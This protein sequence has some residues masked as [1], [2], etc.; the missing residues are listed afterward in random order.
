MAL[1]LQVATFAVNYRGHPF[2]ES[3]LENKPMLYSLLFSG[4][5]VFA[6]ASGI[7]PELLEKFELVELPVGLLSGLLPKSQSI[8]AYLVVIVYFAKFVRLITVFTV[9]EITS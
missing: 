7:S 4:S 1:A 5:A 8:P 6:L 2:M 3:L 9:T